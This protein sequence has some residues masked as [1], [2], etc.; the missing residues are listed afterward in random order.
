[1]RP[2]NA[3]PWA[4]GAFATHPEPLNDRIIYIMENTVWFLRWL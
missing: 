2:E 4:E 3:K 1:M